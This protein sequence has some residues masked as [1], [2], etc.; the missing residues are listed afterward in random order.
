MVSER[1]CCLSVF[2]SKSGAG[3]SGTSVVFEFFAYSVEYDESVKPLSV[4]GGA[5]GPAA[6]GDWRRL[7]A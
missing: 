3:Y 5:P 2:I 4:P 1:S 7:G 6:P